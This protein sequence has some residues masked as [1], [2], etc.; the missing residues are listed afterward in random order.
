MT[1]A[2]LAERI[3]Q[4]QPLAEQIL[5]CWAAQLTKLG[6]TP[7]NTPALP[8]FN[9]A[10]YRLVKDP[11][12]GQV[13]LAGDWLNAHGYKLGNVQFHASGT[14]YAEYD[15]VQPHPR[16]P[17]W[18]IEALVAWGGDGAVKAEYRLLE[19]PEP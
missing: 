2:E 4:S 19:A 8:D 17:Q 6:F 9:T 10:V 5:Q 7:E 15:I 3:A 11:Y 14:I 1:D 13:D 16:D 12:S 18:F